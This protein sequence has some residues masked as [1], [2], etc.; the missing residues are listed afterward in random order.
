MLAATLVALFPI[1]LTNHKRHKL[2]ARMDA[3]FLI[4]MADMGFHRVVRDIGISGYRFGR[5]PT[6]KMSEYLSLALR[7]RIDSGDFR[8]SAANALHHIVRLP[9]RA[10]RHRNEQTAFRPPDE[11]IRFARTPHPNCDSENARRS[12]HHT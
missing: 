11:P 8:A 1:A 10:D 7:Q 5:L 9:P 12:E 4:D 3:G 6:R 2:F